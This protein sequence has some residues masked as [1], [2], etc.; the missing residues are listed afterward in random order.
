LTGATA[1]TVLEKNN[2]LVNKNLVPND[3]RGPMVTSG[4]RLG[5]NS[6]ALRFM[7]EEAIGVIGGL[8]DKV[9]RSV[10]PHGDSQYNFPERISEAVR[11]E[12]AQLCSQYPISHYPAGVSN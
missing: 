1:Q 3:K 6:L 2:I 5:T 4:L 10:E 9:L 11:S 8:I 7:S 12:V